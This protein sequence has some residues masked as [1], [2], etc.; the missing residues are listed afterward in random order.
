VSSG[1]G[2]ENRDYGRR[3]SVVLITRP[4]LS[5]NVS[6]NFADKRR[7]PGR[8]S[9]LVDSGHGVIVMSLAEVGTSEAPRNGILTDK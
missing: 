6:T 9:S 3:G 5:V 8:Y 1:S 7:S 4:P 2:L